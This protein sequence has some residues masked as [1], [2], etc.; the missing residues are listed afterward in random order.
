MAVVGFL[1]NA[2]G[3]RSG[4]SA[5]ANSMF[6]TPLVAQQNGTAI[7]VLLDCN[8][9]T[10]STTLKAVVYDSAHSALLASSSITY[11]STVAG[12][13][14][15]ALGTPLSIVAGTTYYVGYVC[16]TA[17]SVS[18]EASGP[19]AWFVS[20]GQ[21]VTSPANPLVGGS[22]NS[23]SLMVALE[24]DGTSP[25]FGFSVDQ[26]SGVTLSSSN[27]IATCSAAFRRGARSIVTQLP[28]IGKW[29]A[30]ILLGGPTLA[31]GAAVGIGSAN[32]AT[33][34]A[35]DTSLSYLNWLRP[36]GVLRL[37]G[38]NNTT[39]LTYATGDVIGIAYDAVNHRLWFNK[40]NGSWFGADTTPGSPVSNTGGAIVQSAAWPITLSMTNGMSLTATIFTLRDRA[41]AQQYAPPS[42]FSAW[43]AAAGPGPAAGRQSA[44]TVI[45]G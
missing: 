10:A 34:Q 7:A 33:T 25:G 44:V 35:T 37:F 36:D 11:T 15:F 17:M 12:Y 14:R 1:G 18:I 16:S 29:Y 23:N 24:L 26:A 20:G 21:S 38:S 40:N 43:S 45:V 42:G 27:T 2:L 13:N 22:S 4:G 31:A 9:A 30:E 19:G 3:S 28:G 41:G 32:W 39:G 5:G 6:M 8:S